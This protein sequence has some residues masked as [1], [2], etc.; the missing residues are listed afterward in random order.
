MYILYSS[1]LRV[2]SELADELND[3]VMT[4]LWYIIGFVGASFW[5][6]IVAM[7]VRG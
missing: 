7:A 2:C 3:N 1:T 5:V 6:N 4:F